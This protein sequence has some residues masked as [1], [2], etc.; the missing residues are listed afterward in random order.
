M[1]PYGQ[2]SRFAGCIFLPSD[3][4]KPPVVNITKCGVGTP[5]DDVATL[6]SN[7]KQ[8]IW[9]FPGPNG[10]IFSRS[11][12]HILR[13]WWHFPSIQL[14]ANFLPIRY[15]TT[16]QRLRVRTSFA[17]FGRVAQDGY[18]LPNAGKFIWGKLTITDFYFVSEAAARYIRW[19]PAYW[20]CS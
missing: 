13:S 3:D 5:E 1:A 11:A 14:N 6:Q 2:A 19:R 17:E 20:S 7:L 10:P 16:P 15:I 8:E 12:E 4:G 18:F 9:E